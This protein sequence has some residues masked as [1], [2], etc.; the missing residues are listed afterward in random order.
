MLG[1][2]ALEDAFVGGPAV[3][4][5][6]SDFWQGRGCVECGDGE[7]LCWGESH[8][9]RRTGVSGP[10]GG[11]HSSS[12]CD[13][14]IGARRREQARP[15]LRQAGASGAEEAL[16]ALPGE[17]HTAPRLREPDLSPVQEKRDSGMRFPVLQR[18]P[19]R[20]RAQSRSVVRDGCFRMPCAARA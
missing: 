17:V 2:V 5:V 15:V 20:R 11:T 14:A 8:G 7:G 6:V 18:T 19:S 12:C 9:G 16:P 1:R 13:R 3:P 10:I 4:G